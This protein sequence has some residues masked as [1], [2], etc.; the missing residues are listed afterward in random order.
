MI[1]RFRT[2]VASMTQVEIVY[3]E[4]DVQPLRPINPFAV[5]HTPNKQGEPCHTV[6]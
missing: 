2:F 3:V 1:L 4:K 5:P 6:K